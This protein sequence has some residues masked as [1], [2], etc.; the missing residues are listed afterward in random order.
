MDLLNGWGALER[1][2]NISQTKPRINGQ[3]PRIKAKKTRIKSKSPIRGWVFK[4]GLFTTLL[5]TAGAIAFGLWLGFLLILD[6]NAVLWLNRYLPQWSQIPIAVQ[7]PPQTL[8]DIEKQAKQDKL[9]RGKPIY[10]NS[11]ILIPFFRSKEDCVVGNCEEIVELRIYL[12]TRKSQDE[13]EEYYSLLE[14]I[15]IPEITES[16]AVGSLAKLNS[17]K[18]VSSNSVPLTKLN[19]LEN[20]PNSGIWLNL[21]GNLVWDDTTITYG[22]ILYYNPIQKQ[23]SVILPWTSLAGEMPKWE[24]VTGRGHPELVVNQTIGLQTKFQVYQLQNLEIAP[25]SLN[26]TNPIL[27][28]ISLAESLLDHKAYEQALTLSSMGIWTPALQQLEVLKRKI[29]GAEWT[30]KVQAQ[31]DVIAIHAQV[32]QSQCQQSWT[33]LKQKILACLLDGNGSEALGVFEASLHTSKGETVKEITDLLETD[34]QGLWQG[35]ETLI[36]INPFDQDLKAWATLILAAKS[37]REKAIA[38]LEGLPETEGE[39]I[40]AI[41]QLLDQVGASLLETSPY[42]IEISKIIGA[43]KPIKKV[44]L[45]EWLQPQEAEKLKPLEAPQTWYKIQ[46]TTFDDGQRWRKAS[47]GDLQ[48]SNFA[49]AQQLWHL[50]GLD[51][52]PRMQITTKRADGGEEITL[53]IVKAIQLREGELELLAKGIFFE[54][55][56]KIPLQIRPLAHTNKALRWLEPGFVSL[57]DLYNLQPKWVSLILPSLWRNLKTSGHV[58]SHSLPNMPSLLKEMG[59]W[60][61]QSIDLTGNNK[62]DAVLT[63]YQDQNGKLKQPPIGNLSGKGVEKYQQRTIIFADTGAILYSEFKENTTDSLVAIAD[64]RDDGLPV[65]VIDNGESYRFKRWL[66][67]QQGFEQNC[68]AQ[69]PP[70]FFDLGGVR[71]TKK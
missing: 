16:F 60:K 2:D 43:A 8:V 5:T 55:N 24:Q 54:E 66:S 38:Y 17:S 9:K 68:F 11:E 63:L 18:T 35:I 61:V 44:N 57:S 62:P 39:T 26:F 52:D 41:E 13:E 33:N 65:L 3:K 12:L 71:E 40:V 25:K 34:D 6:P 47:F 30:E 59:M 20:A 49:P 15:T 42:N 28:P 7:N 1:L 58:K 14:E 4:L 19:R 45:K 31:M 37:G 36:K 32:S 22:E 53:A 29:K 10:L 48:L 69:S 27:K 70:C 23:I 64:L 56:S 50:L 46:V 51:F 21:S 67:K